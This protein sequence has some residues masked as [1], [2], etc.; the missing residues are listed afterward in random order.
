[1]S[2]LLQHR[3]T[4]LFSFTWIKKEEMT[5]LV[6]LI[7][8]IHSMQAGHMEKAVKYSE[9]ALSQIDRLQGTSRFD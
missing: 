7:T 3:L 9:K 5:A 2:C 6:Y 8:V 4:V 1:M